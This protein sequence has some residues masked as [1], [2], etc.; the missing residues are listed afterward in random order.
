MALINIRIALEQ[1][2]GTITPAVSTAWENAAF[3]PAIGVPYQAVFLLQGTPQNPT[4]G[5]GFYR[6]VG[7]FQ[8]NL[9]YPIQFGT[10]AAITQ[11]EK[12]QTLFKRGASFANGGITVKV[13][14]TPT[15]GAGSVDDGGRFMVPVKISYFA[16]I[17]G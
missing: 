6:A 10:L 9:M 16:D 14:T 5:D 8:V 7:I 1:A 11:A 13:M 17:F 4:L 3:A 12:I 15:I 2:L